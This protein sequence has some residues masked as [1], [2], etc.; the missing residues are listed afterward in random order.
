MG[1]GF[2]IPSFVHISFTRFLFCLSKSCKCFLIFFHTLVHSAV[3]GLGCCTGRS[4]MSSSFLVAV[5]DLSQR[6]WSEACSGSTFQVCTQWR[7]NPC[8][9][10]FPGSGRWHSC[11]STCPRPTLPHVL[12]LHMENPLLALLAF[13]WPELH[14]FHPYPVVFIRCVSRTLP[15]ILILQLF[16]A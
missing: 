9:C 4:I 5:K 10:Y 11:P 15:V 8:L 6:Y 3:G 1:G 14:C 2:G 13:N 7:C 12:L 16:A